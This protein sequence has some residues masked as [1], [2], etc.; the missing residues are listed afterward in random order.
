LRF[1]ATGIR[2]TEV[3]YKEV[4]RELAVARLPCRELLE[5]IAVTR[6]RIEQ[7]S[8]T[9]DHDDGSCHDCRN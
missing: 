6:L 8:I 9:G 4:M 7:E 1:A 3:E 5:Q 2:L